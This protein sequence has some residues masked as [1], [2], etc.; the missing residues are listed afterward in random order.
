M[1]SCWYPTCIISAAQSCRLRCILPNVCLY[2]HNQVCMVPFVGFTA[3]LTCDGASPCRCNLSFVHH[4]AYSWLLQSRLRQSLRVWEMESR[5]HRR[6]RDSPRERGQ[7]LSRSYNVSVACRRTLVAC[8]S[9]SASTCS[10]FI[11][12]QSRDTRP[13]FFEERENRLSP[14][15]TIDHAQLE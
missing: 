8:R 9:P 7:A 14:T 3:Q 6:Y 11:C 12:T 13:G 4:I 5:N 15:D 10:G 2:Y 1:K